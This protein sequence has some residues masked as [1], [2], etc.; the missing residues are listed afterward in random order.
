MIR[1][2]AP[3]RVDLAGGT[4]DIWPICHILDTPAVTVNLALNLRAEA[5]VEAT[6]DGRVRIVSE[7]L[8]TGVDLPVDGLVHDRLP[9]ATRLAAWFGPGDGLSIRLSSRVPPHAGLGG[10]STVGVAL[11]GA[12]GRLRGRAFDIQ[13]LQNI[14]TMVLGTPTGYQDYYP[15]LH[16]GLNVLVARPDGVHV[17]RLAGGEAFLGRHLLLA[18]TCIEHHSGLTN[19]EVVRRFFDGDASVRAALNGIARSAAA[20]RDAL[21]ARDLEG[22]AGAMRAEWDAR[23]TLSPVV[24]DPRIEE[25]ADAVARAGALAAK[26]CGAGGGGCMVILARD[27]GDPALAEAVAGTGGRLVPCGP[28]ADGLRVEG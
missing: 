20:V 14:E 11:A 8:G 21:V 2:S 26:I 22:V 5:Q 10:S 17:E 13:T 25:M 4:I 12:L 28:A 19:W 27:A 16:G 15:P 23:R 3:A 9:L 6:D 7:D 24:S 1:A 18:D